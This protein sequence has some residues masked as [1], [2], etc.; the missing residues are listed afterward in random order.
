M[1]SYLA[2]DNNSKHVA[3]E[4]NGPQDAL[5]KAAGLLGGSYIHVMEKVVIPRIRRAVY[6]GSFD[7]ITLGHISVIR[8]GAE[9]FDELIVAIAENPQKQYTF[10]LEDR[11][12]ML[13][14]VV[15]ACKENSSFHYKDDIAE[16]TPRCRIFAD[17]FAGRFTI[18]YAREK[19]AQF[20]L[21]GL[22]N[23]DDFIM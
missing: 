8:A 1:K 18:D 19:K 22:R 13:K 6:A 4:A 5:E 14:E 16:E 11:L 12:A 2:Y 10:S 9:L 7:P 23:E 17:S 3:V 21:R 20:L 15:D